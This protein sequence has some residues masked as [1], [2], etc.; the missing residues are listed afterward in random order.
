MCVEVAP[1][2]AAAAGVAPLALALGARAM[3]LRGPP[4]CLCDS[5][6]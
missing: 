1:V 3:V 5:H 6:A 2:T 4:G